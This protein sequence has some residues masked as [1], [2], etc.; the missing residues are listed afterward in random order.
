[1]ITDYS[2]LSIEDIGKELARLRWVM[3]RQNYLLLQTLV[4]E[5]RE[6]FSKLYQELA[7]VPEYEREVQDADPS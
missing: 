7:R 6:E 3:L 1:M 2:A 4:G 5:Q